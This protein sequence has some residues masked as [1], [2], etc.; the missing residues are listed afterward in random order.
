[1]K[2]SENI[3]I[4]VHI[5]FCVHRCFYCDFVSYT[6]KFDK[7]QKYTEAVI[8]EIKNAD[9]IL[10]NIENLNIGNS[11]NIGTLGHSESIGHLENIGNLESE[12]HIESSEN[13]EKQE[14]KGNIL[15]PKINV[16]TIYFGGGTPSAID[17]KYIVQILNQIRKKFNVLPDAEITIEI[18]PGTLNNDNNKLTDYK[19]AGFNRISMGLQVTQNELLKKIGRIHT[20]EQFLNTYNMARELGFNNI[21]VDLM[22]GIPGQTLENVEDSLQ[23]IINLSPE[24][25]SV[26]SLILEEG[27]PMFNWVNEGKIFLPSDEIERKMY[28]TV[29]RTLEKAGYLQYEISNFAKNGKISKHNMNCWKQHH[30]LGFGVAAHSYYN[31]IRFFN[32]DNFSK[33]IQEP[34][35]K[36]VEEKQSMEDIQKEFMLLGLRTIEGVRISDFKRKFATNPII[37]YKSELDKLVKEGLIKI[38]LDRIF[39]TNKGLDFANLVWEEFV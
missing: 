8:S 6:N 39:L 36:N 29:K 17:S 4:Y 13:L 31:N 37:L 25:I 9:K 10:K 1:M 22:I 16:D 14:K 28:W 11:K 5:P 2:N 21:S 30:Y 34:L 18:N 33:Y 26:Y 32:T 3:G 7:Q 35:N 19:K 38:D 15:I 27:T 24:H 12:E 23:K 20:F